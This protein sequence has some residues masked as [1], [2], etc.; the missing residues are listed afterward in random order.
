MSGIDERE[1]IQCPVCGIFNVRGE[2]K[3]CVHCG[4]VL[5]NG[6]VA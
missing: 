4:R 1:W 3:N 2:E 6:N 5:K